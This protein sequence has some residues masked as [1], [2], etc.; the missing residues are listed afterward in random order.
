MNPYYPN[1]R[2]LNDLIR[3]FGFAKSNGELLISRLKEWD[4][5]NDSVQVISQRKRHKRFSSFFAKEDR[6]CCC[7][8]VSG[9]FDAIGIACNADEWRLFIDS[10]K[11]LKA[12]LLHKG[13]KYPSLPLAHVVHLKEVYSS[14]NF[15]LQQVWLGSYL[16]LQDGGFL[17]GT[18][19]MFYQESLFS[20]PLGQ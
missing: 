9:L 6:L 16:R 2:D 18:A 3:A 5:L 15:E 7:N 1:Q 12:V 19:R 13:N 4:L 11:S 17:D 14:V 20:L 10:S 8:H